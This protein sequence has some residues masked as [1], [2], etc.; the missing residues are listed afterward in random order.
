MHV[1]AS[2]QW[3]SSIAVMFVEDKV[4]ILSHLISLMSYF[5]YGNF[6]ELLEQIDI[7]PPWILRQQN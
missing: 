1:V 5:K 7:P 4:A 2:N 6:K 3:L